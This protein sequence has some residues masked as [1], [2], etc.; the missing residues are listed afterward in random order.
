MGKS[1]RP[2]PKAASEAYDAWLVAWESAPSLQVG[3]APVDAAQHA[4][5]F[6]GAL[7]GKVR[8]HLVAAHLLR[9]MADSLETMLARS[10]KVRPRGRP[11]NARRKIAVDLVI[12]GLIG[13]GI[14]PKAIDALLKETRVAASAEAAKQRRKSVR[15]IMDLGASETAQP[16]S[17]EGK[18]K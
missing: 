13:G 15:R 6:A 10:E 1:R 7:A 3:L 14:P 12:A 5:A 8:N 11:A 9:A 18:K 2:S 16:A 17:R 4:A